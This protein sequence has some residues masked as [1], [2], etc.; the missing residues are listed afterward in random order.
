MYLS[1]NLVVS[2][3]Y[4]L[5]DFMPSAAQKQPSLQAER[6][7]NYFFNEQSKRNI[8]AFTYQYSESRYNLACNVFVLCL[9]SGK[10]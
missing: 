5:L 2:Q 9:N 10:D 6:K 3:E 1:S 8:L 7:I 4:F